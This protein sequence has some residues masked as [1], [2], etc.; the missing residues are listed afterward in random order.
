MIE[1]HRNSSSTVM[2]NQYQHQKLKLS[3]CLVQEL[4]LQNENR[5]KVMYI[6]KL[7]IEK[8]YKMRFK[9]ISLKQMTI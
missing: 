9:I 1:L 6:I 2:I 4:L 7:F 5:L 3:N 8:F